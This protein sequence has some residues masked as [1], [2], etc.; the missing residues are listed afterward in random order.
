MELGLTVDRAVTTA[1]P[2]TEEV[3]DRV[4]DD[5]ALQWHTRRWNLKK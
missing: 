5:V 3:D 1:V 4:D 2:D